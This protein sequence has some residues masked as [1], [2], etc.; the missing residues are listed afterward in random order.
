MK[1]KLLS[2]AL[3]GLTSLVLAQEKGIKF[4]TKLSWQQIKAKAAAENKSIF[5]DVFATWCESCKKMDNDTYSS[6]KV[7]AFINERFISVKV[8][9]DQIKGDNEFIKAWYSDAAKIVKDYHIT[10]FP[11][12]LFFSPN[13][14]LVNRSVGLIWEDDLIKNARESLDPSSQVYTK[15][16]KFWDGKLKI[17][18]KPKL[19]ILAKSIGEY[20][21]AQSI[22]DDYINN[23][24]FKLKEEELFEKDNLIFLSRFMGSSKSRVFNLFKQKSEKI[25]TVMG[26][27]GAEYAIM[28]FIDNKHVPK[29]NTWAAV[30]PDWN[31]LERKLT[32]MY[33]SL[34][35]EVVNSQ[36]ATYYLNTKNW[37]QYAIWYE[38][39]LEKAYK[40]PRYDINGMTWPLFQ[41]V[42]DPKVLLFACDTVMKYAMEEWYQNEPRIWDTYANLLYKIGRKEQAIEWEEKAVKYSNYDKEIMV[43]LDKMKRNEKTWIVTINNF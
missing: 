25:N 39:Y 31:I 37:S 11:T 16:Q 14:K 22:A 18:E 13:G 8:Q 42:D 40:H 23:Y 41:Y 20:Q 32:K 21:I 29:E 28:N 27:Y 43:N 26:Y 4:E 7:G 15:F 19:A 34:G 10:G 30:M 33:G 1:F 38:K 35:T 2:L 5:M 24:L 3:I 17:Y 36:R 12:L 9:A 6:E